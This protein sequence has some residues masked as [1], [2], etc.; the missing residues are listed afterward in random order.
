MSTGVVFFGNSE[1]LLSNVIFEYLLVYGAR[2]LAAADAPPSSRISTNSAREGFSWRGYSARKGIPVFEPRDPNESDFVR[3]VNDLCPDLL[4][5]AGY[6]RRLG[7][8]LTGAARVASVNFHASLLPAYRGKHPVF[9]ALRNGEKSTGMTVHLID[10]GLDTGA[11]VYRAAVRTRKEDTVSSL[12]DRILAKSDVLVR[13]LVSDAQDNHL[14]SKPQPP[15]AGSYYSGTGEEDFTI[16]WSMPAEQI[17]RR[18]SA[19][20]GKCF[21]TIGGNRIYCLRAVAES[22]GPDKT[23]GGAV[24][25]QRAATAGRIISIGRGIVRVAAG[26]GFL[27]LAAVKPEGKTEMSASE[28]CRS[29]G[30]TKG[31]ILT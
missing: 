18:I 27:G 26:D 4:V 28:F 29:L 5:A 7:A 10:E 21:F 15:G 11:I 12:Y 3:R 30:Y 31:T 1:S 16:Y 22:A 20:P 9:W 25:G 23:A 14:P 13:R 24:I 6:T 19:T 17:R 2:F 8:E